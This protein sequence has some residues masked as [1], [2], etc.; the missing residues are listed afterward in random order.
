MLESMG[1]NT[2]IDLEKLMAVRELV[3]QALPGELMYGF[4]PGAGL[5]KG[6]K[7]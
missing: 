2:G 3:Q 1:L 6:F 5:P 7:N 4:V